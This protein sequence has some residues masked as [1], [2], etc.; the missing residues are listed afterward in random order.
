MGKLSKP[1]KSNKHKKIKFVDPFY[2]GER[3]ERMHAGKNLAPVSTEQGI[4][5]SLK[6][7]MRRTEQA[8]EMNK[9]SRKQKKE[10]MK[11]RI[12]AQFST[13]GAKREFPEVADFKKKKGEKPA[14]FMQRVE[15][16]TMVAI[17]ESQI[18]STF[19]TAPDPL[20]EET[21]LKAEKRKETLKSKKQLKKEKRKEKMEERKDDFEDFKDE[22]KFGEVVHGLPSLSVRPKH[23][24]A[25]EKPA[26]KSLLLYD[27]IKK[28]AQ[29]AASDSSGPSGTTPS[30]KE[31]GKGTK[32]KFLSPS[33]QMR[34]DKERQNAIELYRKMKQKSSGTG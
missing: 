5:R 16:A 29:K 22:V 17:K 23:A 15:N 25:N 9:K 34:M 8:K 19:K 13:V 7:L 28:N 6:D 24:S 30:A 11:K 26:V 32:R 14:E 1:Q 27:V 2:N 20:I 4:S 3:K 12:Q 10:I 21:R 31:L 18:E 33:Q